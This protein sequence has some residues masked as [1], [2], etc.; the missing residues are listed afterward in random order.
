MLIRASLGF[1]TLIR[2]RIVVGISCVVVDLGLADAAARKS[3]VGVGATTLAILS[4]PSGGTFSRTMLSTQNPLFPC[5]FFVRGIAELFVRGRQRVSKTVIVRQV[6]VVA[7]LVT[8]IP[9]GRQAG[10]AATGV[11]V[12]RTIFVELL[13]KIGS[14]RVFA[15]VGADLEIFVIGKRSLATFTSAA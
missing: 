11:L 6:V 14:I 7:V 1:V 4:L 8:G 15:R 3:V 9:K 12:L 5:S 10:A 13:F 2:G